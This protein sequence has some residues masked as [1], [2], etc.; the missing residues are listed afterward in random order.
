MNATINDSASG[1][2]LCGGAT[3]TKI[4]RETMFYATP[5]GDVDLVVDVPVLTCHGCGYHGYGEAGERA[6]TEAIYRYHGR[7]TPWEIVAVREKLGFTQKT[8]ADFLGVGHAS[9]ERWETGVSMQNQGM[10]NLILLLSNPTHKCWLD[11][12]RRRREV[13]IIKDQPVPNFERFRSLTDA[14]VSMMQ[15][16][17]RSFRLRA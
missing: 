13:R 15:D 3:E 6:R 16:A 8:F 1:C 7:L 2:P 12:E 4:V 5:K 11:S 14:D 10:D 17:A 9:V